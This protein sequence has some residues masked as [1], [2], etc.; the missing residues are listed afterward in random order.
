MNK[1]KTFALASLALLTALPASAQGTDKA[2]EA[3]IDKVLARM[4]LDEKVG[5]MTELAIDMLGKFEGDEF[6]LNQEA[7]DKYIGQ[8]KIGSVLNAPGRALTPQNWNKIIHA[9]NDASLKTMGIP[10]LYGLDQNHGATYTL[11][12]TMFPQPINMAASFNTALMHRAGEI[13]GYETRA[14]DCPWTYSPTLDLGRDARWPRI[15]ESFGEDCLVNAEFGRAATLGFQG[16]DPNHIDEQHIAACPKHY[17]AYG[18]PR[19]GKDRTPAYVPE[20]LLREKYFK[21][22]RE[23]VKAGAL[24]LMV[25]SGSI[26]GVPMHANKRYLTDWLKDE[27][28][29]SGMIVSDWADI[30]NLFTREHVVETKKEAIAL[31]VNAGVD[32]SM[33][34]YDVDF[35]TLLKQCVEEGLVPQSRVD[36]AVRR[37]LRMKYRLGLFD[38]PDTNLKKYPKY[39]CAEFAKESEDAATETM[40]LLKNNEGLLPLKKGIRVLVTG[41]NANTLRPLDG[42]WSYTWQGDA[43]KY[44]KGKLTILEALKQKLG[45]ENVTFAQGVSY[46]MDGKYDEENTPDIDAAV[47]AAEGVDLIIACIGENSYTETPGNLNE[48]KLSE[49]QRDLVKALAKTGKKILLLLNEGRP[50]IIADIEPLATAVVDM[51]IPGENGAPALARLLMGEDNF[52]GRLPYTYPRYDAA[53][54]TYDYRASEEVGTMEGAYDYNAQVDVQW[55]FGFG[56]S[57]TTFTY[58][59]LQVDKQDFMLSDVLNVKVN[60]TNSGPVEGKESVLLFSRDLVASMVPE[61]R[62]LRAFTKI[63]LKPGESKVV[64]F[65]LPARDLAFV[66][67]DG[68]WHLE[69]GKFMLQAG[70]KIVYVNCKETSKF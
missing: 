15:W 4:T 64:E 29:F 31:A 62:R 3:K 67:N 35:P 63:S 5:Q 14:A 69:K 11:G 46:K 33:V 45:A 50:R 25:N 40:V 12:G 7:L 54:T 55:P 37:I 58:S 36:D 66:G 56:K 16:T 13:T 42:G 26:N 10:T 70:D 49:N 30:N 20:F 1:I 27:A 28:G 51:L 8:Y 9:I 39:G 41:P 60:V 17:M 59:D 44:A 6:V 2:M 34:P 52:S 18:I 61:R 48:L 53:L 23:N 43:D 19:T 21:P 57:Y 22:F 24:S 38:K 32:M 68:Q 65:Q 47:R